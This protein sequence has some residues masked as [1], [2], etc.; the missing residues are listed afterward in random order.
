V[1]LGTSFLLLESC[2]L[3]LETPEYYHERE[4]PRTSVVALDVPTGRFKVVLQGGSTDAEVV[5]ERAA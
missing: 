1:V 5:E 3:L 4:T 2:S